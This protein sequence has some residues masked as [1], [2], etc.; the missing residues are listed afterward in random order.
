[1]TGPKISSSNTGM[2][3]C[4]SATTV[5]SKKSRGAGSRARAADADGR[6]ALRADSTR[7]DAVALL[8]VDERTDVGVGSSPGP[9][10]SAPTTAAT[11]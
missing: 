2:V 1:M 11:R 10:R 9:T 3:G 8:L 7:P 5:G 6:T 4:T